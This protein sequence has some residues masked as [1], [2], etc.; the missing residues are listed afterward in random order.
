MESSRRFW[1]VL[2]SFGRLK[3]LDHIHDNY[4]DLV[5]QIGGIIG[6]DSTTWS[7]IILGRD[8]QLSTW[9]I[10]SLPRL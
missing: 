10:P 3:V 8:T 2:K 4:V 7:Y 5:D 1:N 6:V 9:R